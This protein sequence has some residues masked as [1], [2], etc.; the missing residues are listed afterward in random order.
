MGKIL[1]AIVFVIACGTAQSWRDL[2]LPEP[3]HI[4]GTVSD[5]LGAPIAGAFI[6]YAGPPYSRQTDQAGGFDIQTKSPV[7][8]IRKEGFQSELVR[9]LDATVVR[10]TLR[11]LD[12]NEGFPACSG[13]GKDRINGR[14]AG[15]RFPRVANV[16]VGRRANDVDFVAQGYYVKTKRG[17]K[18]IVHGR[19]PT[20]S[21]GIPSDA[22]VW[23]SVEF[24]EIAYDSEA[25]RLSMPGASYPTVIFGAISAC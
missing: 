14:E 9:T 17:W 11:R 6:D 15:L 8:V 24:R 13:T 10:S 20:W 4:E 1:M 25:H 19:G 16:R 7:F 22:D 21:W 12:Q 18:G 5:P 3:R 23:Q 2:E